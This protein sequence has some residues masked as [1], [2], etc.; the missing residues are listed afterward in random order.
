[1]AMAGFARCRVDVI[2]A[3]HVHTSRISDSALRYKIPGYTALLVR[4]GTATSSRR[5]GELNA[6]NLIRI[7]R[8]QI[9][10]DCLT[11]DAERGSFAVSRTD[12]FQLKQDGGTPA[13]AISPD[14]EYKH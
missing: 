7:E 6:W 14:G 1:M 2:L 11:W 4:A 10:I 12:R 9:S 8:P 13:S 5:R 3:G